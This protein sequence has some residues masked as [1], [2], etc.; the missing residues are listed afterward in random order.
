MLLDFK[1][2]QSCGLSVKF[3]FSTESRFVSRVKGI[4]VI[5]VLNGLNKIFL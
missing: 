2:I 4:D 3:L 1:N 5:L